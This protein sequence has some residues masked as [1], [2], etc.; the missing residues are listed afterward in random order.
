V[1]R[2]EINAVIRRSEA[3]IHSLGFRLPPFANWSPQSW[4]DR[5]EEVG[6]IVDNKLGWDITDF[7]SGQFERR[8]LVLF[9][10]RNG[11]PRHLQTGEGKLYAEKVMVTGVGQWNPLHFH[12]QKA[13]DIIN[14]GGGQLAVQLY[15]SRDD[16][17]LA[18]S[19]VVI[20]T[21]GVQR[22][23]PA[24]DTVVLSPGESI[25][26]PPRCYHKFW[27]VGA[28]VLIGEVSLVND[29]EHDNRFF[30]PAA[31]FP[32]IE[33]DEAPLYLLCTEYGRFWPVAARP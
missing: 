3:F 18:D 24:G 33:E 8:G 29:D 19:E 22:R 30:E 17:E 10:L 27:A 12:W 31:R 16:E 32:A 15:N 5:G 28:P 1:K 14:R 6:E 2:S 4:A 9:T 23:V 20:S 13:E 7:G 25:T 11:H 21:D 26:L